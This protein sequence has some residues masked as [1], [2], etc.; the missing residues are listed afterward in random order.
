VTMQR[1]EG[2]PVDFAPI[3]DLPFVEVDLGKINNPIPIIFND[4]RF[5]E[6]IQFFA[7]APSATRSLLTP[8]SQALLY[9]IIRN[10]RPSDIVE[11]G[12]YK[13]GTSESMARALQSNG[14]GTLH[15]L[16]PFDIERFGANLAHWPE[17]L[18]KHVCY[19]PVDSMLFFAQ[20]DQRKIRPEL[21]LIDGNHDYEFVNFDLQASAQR[22]TRG[23]FI[24]LDN[25]SQAGPYFAASEFLNNNSM[26]IDCGLKPRPK[27]S[28]KAFEHRSNIPYTDFFVIR[29]PWLYAITAKP[30]TFGVQRWTASPVNG[31]GLTLG[32]GSPAGKLNVQLILRAFSEDRIEEIAFEGCHTLLD[33]E[34][35]AD[36]LLDRPA[37]VEGKF[38]EYWIETWLIWQ[39]EDPLLLKSAPAPF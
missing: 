32:E 17:E 7:E 26:W 18:R 37:A 36:I 28:S 25:V 31:L 3:I 9:T 4:P 38:H 16:S 14:V 1:T 21:V 13:G 11:I 33:G 35:I 10:L 8:K 30:F 15:T 12:T 5:N 39:G 20:L 24:F 27:T 34:Q 19:Y 2:I 23:G 6:T 29:A 22:I